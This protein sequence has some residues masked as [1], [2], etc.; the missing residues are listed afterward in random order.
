MC[1]R[2]RNDEEYDGDRQSKISTDRKRSAILHCL[3]SSRGFNEQRVWPERGS[4]IYPIPAA[5]PHSHN[6]HNQ[7]LHKARFTQANLIGAPVNWSV[8]E[9]VFDRFFPTTG[10][11]KI[12]SSVFTSVGGTFTFMVR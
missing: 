5:P 9:D 6:P 3:P 12:V 2:K 8:C 11:A 10:V 1:G 4:S 7:N